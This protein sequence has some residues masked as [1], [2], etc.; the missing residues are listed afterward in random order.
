MNNKNKHRI[1]LTAGLAA[2]A[3][4]LCALS[5]LHKEYK[6]VNA[7]DINDYTE[8]DKKHQANNASGL[9]EELEKITAPGSSGS[10][11]DLWTS[12]EKAYKRADGKIFDYYSSITNYTTANQCGGYSK[13]GS[14]YN[15][16]HSIPKS[17]WGGSKNNQGSDPFIVVPTDGYVNNARSSFP[18]GYVG[19]VSKSFS[20]S[21]LGTVAS[22]W[23]ISGT[24]FEPDDSL[25]GDFARIYYYT[26][27]K[28]NV[29]SWTSGDG[30]KCFSGSESTNFGL[31]NYSVRL[32]SE[33]SELDPV[34]EWEESVNDKL[35]S[36]QGN[37]NP[38]IDHPEYANTLWGTNSD[39]TQYT[40]ASSSNWVKISST[41][42]SMSVG[43]VAAI[44]ATSSDS[45]DI[46]WTNSNSSVVQLG[47]TVSASGTDITLTA[48]AAGSA[49][50]TAS[51]TID[52][53]TYSKQCLVV[54]TK[55]L[56]S[57]TYTGTPTKTT[58]NSGDSFNPNGLT[59]TATYTDT[60][61][62]DVTSHVV[63]TPNPLTANTTSVTGTYGGLTITVSGLTVN[64]AS[65]MSI[66]NTDV[67]SGS[68]PKTPTDFTAA[69]GLKFKGYYTG[70][71]ESSIQFK[72]SQGYLYNTEALPLSSLTINV[73]T[74]S[75]TVYGGKA[76]NPSTVITGTN[77]TYNLNSYSYFKVANTSN[78]V[79]RANSIEVSLGSSEVSKL[80]SITLSDIQED[81][82]VG[83]SFV[84]PVVTAHYED[85]G[86]DVVTLKAEFS[87]YDM[88]SIGVQTVDVSYTEGDVT[89]EADFDIEVKEKPTLSSL[90][91]TG[92]PLTTT[93]Y[94]GD[95]FL[96]A[97]LT[98]TAHY[99]DN[100]SDD[101]TKDVIWTPNPLTYGITS[102]TG[103]Y[104]GETVVISGLTVNKLLPVSLSTSGQTTS[105]TV[106]D[107]FSYD[108]TCKVTYNKGT[109][110]TITP[111]V[112]SSSV[113]M[114]K[115]G[116]YSVSLSY[117]ENET[118]VSTSYNI[119]VSDKPFV[120]TIKE[121][122][123]KS[124]GASVS[125][126]YG[127]Y[128]GLFKN[129]A[130]TTSTMIMN[131]EYGI[132]LYGSV[133]DNA[134]VENETYIDVTSG[135]L[136]IYNNLYQLKTCTVSTDDQE[137]IKP[138]V[139]PVSVY[140]VTGEESAADLTVANRL[141]ILSGTITVNSWTEGKDSNIT[142]NG[143]TIFIKGVSATA[144]LK[145]KLDSYGTTK[146][147]TFKCFTGFYKTNFQVQFKELMEEDSGITAE[148]F[149]SKL[150]ELTNPICSSSGE[151]ESSLSSVWINLQTNYWAKMSDTHK[152]TLINSGKSETGTTIE[153]AMARYDRICQKYESCTNFI[154]RP[155][156]EYAKTNLL[157][158]INTN[159][160]MI[161]LISIGVVGISALSLYMFLTSKK[162]K[163]PN[164]K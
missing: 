125:H 78:S 158:N 102:V 66:I 32:F 128:V 58:Y 150:L 9:M 139:A 57:L 86:S 131:G 60:T 3:L 140:T 80:S 18:F 114:S 116:T 56:Q 133:P 12:Y 149:S 143:T 10:Y 26:T 153:K 163:V 29:S 48:K 49:T 55:A 63:W 22:G 81:Y 104:Q 136:D 28:Y 1:F 74:G 89:A 113:N 5:S 62:E 72:S 99:S 36:I 33:W 97:G 145:S 161:I 7:V 146:V 135:T 94:S 144:E 35:A 120:N 106:G 141:T 159:A 20:N 76:E 132:M 151:K 30:S 82:Y 24:V 31:T 138:N 21:K 65:S 50:I 68:Y 71:Y 69:S 41:S 61:S 6:Q 155:G 147:A 70:N 119:T 73:K 25:K 51:A 54:V 93:Y 164:V 130:K 85:G 148:F 100:T 96:S 124:S 11:D 87:G 15:R 129:N 39:Y 19:S 123:S 4:S 34:S 127:L 92:A 101:V 27:V 14:C 17:W 103:T 162:K 98:V 2:T 152:Q 46:T 64:Q 115:A 83:D 111:V 112:N 108:G 107:S 95:V 8:C 47:T 77:N 67:P 42:E 156:A 126:V 43:G 37:R 137:E 117:T 134:W 154:G 121:C 45:S 75:F 52:G 23:N 88:S 79:A 122:Y 13:E 59:V 84:K 160:M 110:A 40:H 142:V 53:S 91:L 16:E 109:I 105:Y 118:T 38:F 90:E 44:S 157:I